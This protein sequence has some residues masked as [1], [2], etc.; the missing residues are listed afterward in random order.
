[1]KLKRVS[2]AWAGPYSEFSRIS[3]LESL[4]D[5]M[6]I[7]DMMAWRDYELVQAHTRQEGNRMGRLV[8]GG[9]E[10]PNPVPAERSEPEDKFVICSDYAAP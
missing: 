6:Q 4:I 9:V 2:K 7:Y 8:L 5:R 3:D 1:M 10:K